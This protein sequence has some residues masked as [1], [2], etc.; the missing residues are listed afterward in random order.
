MPTLAKS[1]GRP[2][3]TGVRS[4][5]SP[6]SYPRPWWRSFTTNSMP[7]TEEPVNIPRSSGN[8]QLHSSNED[9]SQEKETNA[10]PQSGS[11]G[12]ASQQNQHLNAIAASSDLVNGDTDTPSPMELV[13]HSF[14]LSS[15]SNLQYAPVMTYGTM[16]P[17][18]L[19]GIHQARMPLP[20]S[21]EEEP[22]YVNAKQYNGILRRRQSRAKA[23][24]EKKL[25]KARKPYL[26]ESRHQHA[27]R[28]AR[29]S[30][31]RFLN[32][33]KLEDNAVVPN[34]QQQAK[35]APS[36]STQPGNSSGSVHFASN[37]NGNY[38][39]QGERGYMYYHQSTNIEQGARN[40]NQEH[41]SLLMNQ[42]SHGPAPCN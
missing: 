34:S 33:K 37:M 6:S 30:G 22:V 39:T 29:G 8:I 32:T 36:A 10:V 17:P 26:H 28:R 19:I 31:G 35:R 1:D 38:D 14:M 5:S 15:Y 27:M 21:M 2:L 42:H 16:V 3:E 23:E 25:I 11:S 41:W 9:D 18:Q 12:I 7:S 20:L 13:G 4:I 40:L 24:I